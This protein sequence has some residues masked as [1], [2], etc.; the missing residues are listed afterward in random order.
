MST[1]L[2]L[3]SQDYP[4]QL[5]DSNSF[6]YAGKIANVGATGSGSLSSQL[7][8]NAI[9]G[10]QWIFTFAHQAQ[11]AHASLDVDGETISVDVSS[12]TDATGDLTAL[13]GFLPQGDDN[14]DNL[15]ALGF[16]SGSISSGVATFQF[17]SSSVENIVAG[18]QIIF[19]IFGGG[20]NEDVSVTLSLGANSYFDLPGTWAAA[21]YVSAI[22]V[23]SAPLSIAA[24]AP[25]VFTG[26]S[27]A[28]PQKDVSV[29]AIAPFVTIEGGIQVP[30]SN[31][32]VAGVA[33]SVTAG[34]SVSIPAASLGISGALPFVATGDIVAVPS[35]NVAVSAATPA[36]ATGAIVSSPSVGV[37]VAAAVPSILATPGVT[38]FLPVSDISLQANAPTIFV[39]SPVP[40][41]PSVWAQDVDPASVWVGSSDAP[42]VWVDEAQ[43][44]A[45]WTNAQTADAVWTQAA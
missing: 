4:V 41:S 29:A 32:G 19:A 39:W 40:V 8:G 27:V 25:S 21:S 23:P 45:T 2:I 36:I 37:A 24:S 35:A 7:F 30:V 34:V 31:L 44:G 12:F 5:I 9:D 26:A 6:Q 42:A 11:E 22:N 33:P 38:I 1:S 3:T 14:I 17:G 13:V 10:Y 28:V 18:D 43:A 15:T 20:D 16:A